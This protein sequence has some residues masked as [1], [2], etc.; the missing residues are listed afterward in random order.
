METAATVGSAEAGGS[1]EGRLT[2]ETAATV[3][4]AEVG[5]SATVENAEVG[6][7]EK[8][9]LTAGLLGASVGEE[10]GEGDGDAPPD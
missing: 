3:E 7:S 9:W 8:S 10:K 2:K 5:E 4:N 6:E 1:G